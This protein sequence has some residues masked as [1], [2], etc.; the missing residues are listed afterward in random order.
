MLLCCTRRGAA[1]GAGA[2]TTIGDGGTIS[3]HWPPRW[4]GSRRYVPFQPLA[5]P[6]EPSRRGPPPNRPR[7]T[8]HRILVRL[9][10]NTPI[11]YQ[12]YTV[13]VCAVLYIILTLYC[14]HWVRVQVVTKR[15]NIAQRISRPCSRQTDDLSLL[16]GEKKAFTGGQPFRNPPP[17]V[18]LHARHGH[19]ITVPGPLRTR[20]VAY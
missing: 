19:A 6:V 15:R 9:A 3:G 13:V 10:C 7:Y 11:P 16:L 12:C 2:T 8:V 4:A 14:G 20:Y 5:L 1:A 18:Y 17:A